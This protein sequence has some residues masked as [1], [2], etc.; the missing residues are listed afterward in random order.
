M[1]K[2]MDYSWPG[3]IRE[4]RH[5]IEKAVILSDGNTLKPEGFLFS[6]ADREVE[7]SEKL[8]LEDV[9]K[10]TIDKALKKH[11]GNL[12]KTA[13]ELGITRKTLYSK[14]EKYDL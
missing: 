5:T 1:N 11:R 9:E 2:L 8:R 12:S 7:S 4:L 13:A 3:N 10:A 6:V 14:I